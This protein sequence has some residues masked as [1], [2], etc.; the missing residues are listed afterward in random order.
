[1]SGHS[2]YSRLCKA[3]E[4]IIANGMPVIPSTLSTESLRA[5]QA[6]MSIAAQLFAQITAQ[7]ISVAWLRM[8]DLQR[9]SL[10]AEIVASGLYD[11][12]NEMHTAY[13]ADQI[14]ADAFERVLSER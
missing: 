12:T 4:V 13:L 10:A 5:K 1:M 14:F 6:V 9:V 7:E 11:G 2:P 3:L 8:T